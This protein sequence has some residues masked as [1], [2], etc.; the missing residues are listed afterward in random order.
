ME[1]SE[2]EHEDDDATSDMAVQA[3]IGADHD[4]DA[5]GGDD[6]PVV[7]AKEADVGNA[8]SWDA[9]AGLIDR[10]SVV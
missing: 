7:Q 5:G 8:G 4:E 9:D 1:R 6:A 2:R 3:K 10:K